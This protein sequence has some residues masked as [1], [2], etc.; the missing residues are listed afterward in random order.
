M[1]ST[2][3]G[4]EKHNKCSVMLAVSTVNKYSVLYEKKFSINCHDLLI[5]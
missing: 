1:Q 4:T 2:Y 3:F 5:D